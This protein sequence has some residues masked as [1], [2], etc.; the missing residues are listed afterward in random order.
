MKDLFFK[1]WG[2][3]LIPIV[4][5]YYIITP[6][7]IRFVIIKDF[8]EWCKW[9]IIP[10]NIMNLCYLFAKYREFRSIIYKRLSWR[11]LFIAWLWHGQTNLHIA[12]EN[13]GPGLI[14]QHG[15]S[16]IIAAKQIGEYFHVNQCVTIGWNND[17]QPTIGNNVTIYA[18]ANVIGGCT[19]GN[20]VIIAAGAVVVK[21]I[22][23]NCIVAGNP[24]TIIK[25][26][27]SSPNV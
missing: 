22:P 27:A 9:K 11:K 16:T 23:D 25:K 15:Y 6:R 21:D 10:C 5:L 2:I 8:Q 19:I 20:N 7:R 18:G 24:A 1:I 26:I 17:K 4:L 3:Q 14:I 13:I 12:C